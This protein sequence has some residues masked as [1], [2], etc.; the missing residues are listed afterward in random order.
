MARVGIGVL[1][2]ACLSCAACGAATERADADECADYEPQAPREWLAASP[3]EFKEA[4]LLA[5]E[6]SEYVV[7]DPATYEQIAADLT[8]IYAKEVAVKG[9]PVYITH[10][11]VDS[12][13]VHLDATGRQQLNSGTYRAWNCP[14]AAYGVEVNA[15]ASGSLALHF[16]PKRL[17]RAQLVNEYR[18]LPHV[19]G[20]LDFPFY[21][22]DG[23]DICREV[24][25]ETRYYVFD[26]ATGDCTF[27]CMEHRYIG[28]ALN[29]TTLELHRDTD[30]D[31][32]DWFK[33]RSDCASRL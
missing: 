31:W 23:S 7:A 16:G 22:F 28:F 26:R 12:V 27:T 14:N 32:H 3:R 29:G 19:V 17:N 25:G 11:D 2:L 8:A 30:A 1:A 24:V 33:A 20:G 13:G 4:E 15:D 18:K 9:W 21:T 6:A 10:M 5:M